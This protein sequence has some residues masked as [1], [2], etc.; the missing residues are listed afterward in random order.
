MLWDLLQR[1]KS[2]WA[3]QILVQVTGGG[4]HGW[5]G[6]SHCLMSLPSEVMP[7]MTSCFQAYLHMPP[8]NLQ[9][10]V[11]SAEMEAAQGFLTLMHRSWAQLQ[12][13]I[14]GEGSN[15]GGESRDQGCLE[16][17]SEACLNGRKNSR[18]EMARILSISRASIHS[19]VS[20]VPPSEEQAVGRLTALL[21]QR[22]PSLTSQLF[23]DLS[24]LIPFLAVSDLMRF[25]PS[26]LANDS[27]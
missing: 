4:V 8:E 20:Q 26:L 10:L 25:P 7:T 1:E 13:G 19:C 2:V 23:I 21:L 17:S 6:D 24:P 5:T 9:Q 22:Y 12:V 11:L 3:L 14:E 15:D 18:E 16:P 27:V